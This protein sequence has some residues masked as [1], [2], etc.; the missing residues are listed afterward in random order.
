M[1]VKIKPLYAVVE[2]EGPTGKKIQ[3]RQ[4][5]RLG[6]FVELQAMAPHIG[7]VY[8]FDP[9]SALRR[10]LAEALSSTMGTPDEVDVASGTESLVALLEDAP[11]VAAAPEPDPAWAPCAGASR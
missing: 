10:T 9:R 1:K 3:M 11:P 8:A 4:S 6:P 7:E 2:V 5:G